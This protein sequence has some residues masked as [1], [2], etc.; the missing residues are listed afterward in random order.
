MRDLKRLSLITTALA[1]LALLLS[2]TGFFV[3]QPNSITVTTGA[4]G[5]GTSTF[6]VPQSQTVKLFATASFNSG[7]KDVTSSAN[8]Q[9]SSPCATVN[10]GVVTGVGPASGVT[11]TATVGG[12]TGSATGT[13]TGSGGQALVIAP[14][15]PFTLATTPTVQ[16]TASQNGTDVTNSVTWSSSDTSILTFSSS[17]GF[18]NLLTTGTSTVT[19]SLATGNSCASGSEVVTVQ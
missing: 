8:W 15:G 16:F 6:S 4:N 13:V 5:G 10:A 18:A 3:N 14:Q 1:A 12:I 7:S 19:A 9:S 2:C 11:I 17:A